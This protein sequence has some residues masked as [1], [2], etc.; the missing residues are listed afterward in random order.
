MGLY[1]EVFFPHLLIV[2][3]LFLAWIVA[4]WLAS[5]AARRK[6]RRWVKVTSLLGLLSVIAISILNL[7]RIV[8]MIPMFQRGIGILS[9]NY[10]ATFVLLLLPSLITLWFALPVYWR[11]IRTPL[12]DDARTKMTAPPFAVSFQMGLLGAFLAVFG[13]LAK[14]S[15]TFALY[16]IF[17]WAAYGVW[18]W[19]ING[20]TSPH[21]PPIVVR[22]G[23]L[24]KLTLVNRWFEPHPIHPHGHRMLVLSRNG[25][26]AT[27]SPWLSDTLNVGPGETYEV[28]MKADNPGVWMDC[29]NLLHAVSGMVLHLMY[30]N[31]TTAYV[32]GTAT[33]NHPE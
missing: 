18:R 26:P 6:T 21:V 32:A 29:H 17:G 12:P 33:R 13:L 1:P 31:V 24:I 30:D 16:C 3:L 15:T 19:R 27:G 25:Q 23:Q 5:H 11:V 10:R 4:A 14:P 7:V 20:K 2:Y 22:E 28:A 8:I 9:A